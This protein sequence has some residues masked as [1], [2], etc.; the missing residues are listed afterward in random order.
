M[1]KVTVQTVDKGSVAKLKDLNMKIFPILTLGAEDDLYQDF[2]EDDTGFALLAYREKM[3]AGSICCQWT[4]NNTFYIKFLGTL[5]R[6]RR[7]GVASALMRHALK[8]AE[9]KD[10]HSAYL[11]VRVDNK[12]A[13]HCARKFGFSLEG[14][15]GNHL[16][17]MEK[18]FH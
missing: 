5:N 11:Y 4:D 17:L 18:K 13:L 6:H 2:V 14:P 16:Y 9:E 12:A 15:S 3:L 1:V 8:K 7:K 10:V